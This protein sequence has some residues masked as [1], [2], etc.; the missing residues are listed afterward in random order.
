MIRLLGIFLALVLAGA[1]VPASFSYQEDQKPEPDHGKLSFNGYSDR[2][3]L[4]FG[5][6]SNQTFPFPGLHQA[7]RGQ[8]ISY[9][10]HEINYLRQELSKIIKEQKDDNKIKL[11]HPRLFAGA[12]SKISVPNPFHNLGKA[13]QDARKHWGIET[14]RLINQLTYS[15]MPHNNSDG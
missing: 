2:T 3:Q 1:T 13:Y 6:Y 12:S 8:E 10:E 5:G 14:S 9:F 4:L 7:N 15:I 11:H